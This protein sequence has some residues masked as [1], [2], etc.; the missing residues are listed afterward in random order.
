MKAGARALGI[1][2]SYRGTSDANTAE[3]TLAGCIVR[4]SRVVDGVVFGSCT[5][6]GTDATDAVIDL[7]ERLG[8]EDV[9]TLL[10]AGIA[11]A[12]Y[13]M[14]DLHRIHDAIDRPVLSI[15]FKESDGLESALC[16][17]FSGDDLDVRLDIYE[18]QPPRRRLTVND[19]TLFV[20]CVGCADEEAADVIRAFT[21]EGGRPEPL[22][23]ARLAARAAN[24]W[25]NVDEY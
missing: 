14:F 20:R 18:R 6:G 1:A 24:R 12:W 13:N 7:T 21:P 25:A 16:E 5:I 3:S 10:L 11:P 23:V 19:E 15:S 4:V 17:A 22:R 9:S 2:E 8:R